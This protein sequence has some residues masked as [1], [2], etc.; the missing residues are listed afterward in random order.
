MGS[1]LLIGRTDL[2]GLVWILRNSFIFYSA[3]GLVLKFCSQILDRELGFRLIQEFCFSSFIG[4]G[5]D[6]ISSGNRVFVT[7]LLLISL[8]PRALLNFF[9]PGLG[10]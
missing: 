9:L 5:K 2:L 8:I 10:F 7:L 6:Q 1:L 3:A 4:L